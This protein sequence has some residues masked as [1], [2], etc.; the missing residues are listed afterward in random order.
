MLALENQRR[1]LNKGVT[2]GSAEQRIDLAA[3]FILNQRG[4]RMLEH[5]GKVEEIGLQLD[6]E[7]GSSWI[8]AGVWIL[9]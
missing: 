1:L 8:S 9:F 7:E 6:G 5:K 2:G 4:Q 3:V